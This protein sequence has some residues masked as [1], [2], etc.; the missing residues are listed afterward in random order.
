MAKT[1]GT[2][3]P[4]RGAPAAPDQLSLH[5]VSYAG[6]WRGQARLTLE[7]F[8]PRAAALG[9]RSVMLVGKRPHLSLLDYDAPRRAGL[10][11]H[12]AF[13]QWLIA[14]ALLAVVAGDPLAAAY[15]GTGS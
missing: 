6:V 13:G 14:G 3:G 2:P 9:Y 7:E 15:L 8:V 11:D 1:N 12:M 10:R 4:A 5:S